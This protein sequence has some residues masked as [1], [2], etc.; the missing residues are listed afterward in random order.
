MREKFLHRIPLSLSLL[1]FPLAKNKTRPY[2]VRHAAGPDLYCY[3]TQGYRI[4]RFEMESRWL[5]G[6]MSVCHAKGLQFEGHR[7]QSDFNSQSSKVKKHSP[8]TAN[9]ATIYLYIF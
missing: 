7:P 8:S 4:T 6:S 2:R 9:T 5:I 1:L 3:T